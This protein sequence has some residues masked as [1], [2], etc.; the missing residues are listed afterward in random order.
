MTYAAQSRAGRS[1]WPMIDEREVSELSACY[2][3]PVRRS[4][5]IQA[6]AYMYAAR[7]R[8]EHDVDRRAEVV[9][10]IQG[11]RDEVWLHTKRSYQVPIYR[12]PTGGI[13]LDE[14]VEEALRREVLEETQLFCRIERFLGLCRYRFHW[15][16]A[17][18]DP[19]T[20]EFA[21]YIFL[22]CTEGQPDSRHSDEVAGFVP[23]LPAQ[24]NDTAAD[25]RNLIGQ[26]RVWG[27]WRALAH[28]LVYEQLTQSL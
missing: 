12:L 22:L 23:V 11:K 8:A 7:W 24:L 5:D 13:N 28:D 9:F 18:D 6:D 2:G 20:V 25:L 21:S 17:A 16:G 4:F 1:R 19:S 15:Q 3:V 10:A 26:R 27:Q 14:R